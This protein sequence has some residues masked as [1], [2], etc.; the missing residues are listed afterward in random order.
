MSLKILLASDGSKNAM[1]AASLVAHMAMVEPVEV[2][3][4]TVIQM[5]EV[6]GMVAVESWLPELLQQEQQQA[7]EVYAATEKVFAG[8]KAS[9]RSL[10]REGLVGYE[11]VAEAEDSQV[12]LVVIGAKG[13]S[14]VDRILLGSVSDYVATHAKCSALVVRETGLTSDLDRNIKV[15]VGYDN[16]ESSVA[17]VEQFQRFKMDR[18]LSLDILAVCQVVRTFRQD[19]LPTVV[20]GRAKMRDAFHELAAEGVKSLGHITTHIQPHVVEAEHVGT[21]IVDFTDSHQSD[22]IVVGDTTR[23][24]VGRFFLGSVSRFVL[25]HAACSVWIARPHQVG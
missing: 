9:L 10:I 24:M 6:G 19:L 5:P 21:A 13:H 22:F 17:A 12:D 20:E 1:Q 4:M 15:T 16:S 23:G 11:L 25:R 7:N 18:E 3:V 2:I 14:A 8:T